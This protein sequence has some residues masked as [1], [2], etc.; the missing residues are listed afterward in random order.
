[1]SHVKGVVL[2]LLF[3]TASVCQAKTGSL[4]ATTQQN[5]ALPNWLVGL[6][7]V[8]GFLFIV[9]FILV[10]KRIF[11]KKEED[12]EDE[13]KPEPTVYENKALDVDV[14]TANDKTTS[15]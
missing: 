15:L 2:V 6:A 3:L 10:V 4:R 12:E 1:M 9:F 8:V 13:E 11:F 7:A 5:G 14:E